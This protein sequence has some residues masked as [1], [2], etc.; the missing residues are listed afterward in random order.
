[1]AA[2]TEHR[3]NGP[4]RTAP[5]R[6]RLE[7]P[8]GQRRRPRTSWIA[9]GLLVLLGFGLAGAI[10]VARVADRKPVVALA[11]PIQ[12]GEQVTEAHLRVVRVG[13]DDP[14]DVVGASERDRLVGL[15]ATTSLGGGTLVSREQFTGGPS[16]GQGQSVVGL[17]LAPGQYPT[18]SLRPGD[19]VMVVRTPG[20]NGVDRAADGQVTVLAES[21]EVFAVEPLSETARTLMVSIAVP[22]QLAAPIA[23]AAAQDRVRLVMVGR[24]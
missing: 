4:T 5:D 16:L 24:G 1:M 17:A 13:T 3:G 20:P 22:E 2:V 15:T 18:A 12:R 10:T 8:G 21:A 7:P 11:Q 23:A 6:L 9:L 19:V 14:V